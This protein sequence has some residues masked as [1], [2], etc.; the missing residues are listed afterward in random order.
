MTTN[1]NGPELNS[2]EKLLKA[3]LNEIVV[4]MRVH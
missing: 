3:Q 2:K 4:E 1:E